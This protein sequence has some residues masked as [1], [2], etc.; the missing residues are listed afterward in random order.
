MPVVRTGTSTFDAD[1]LLKQRRED[2]A[3]NAAALKARGLTTDDLPTPATV[4]AAEAI[5]S[6]AGATPTVSADKNAAAELTKLVPGLSLEGR[7]PVFVR[8]AL[9]V[10]QNEPYFRSQ[11]LVLEARALD[12]LRTEAAY[13]AGD[14]GGQSAPR[15]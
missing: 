4:A 12:N 5:A 10:A 2:A 6:T 9:R 1:Q 7:D 15:R 3:F 13:L 11:P 14:A 8:A